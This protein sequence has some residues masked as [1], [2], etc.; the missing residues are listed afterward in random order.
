[1]PYGFWL[2]VMVLLVVGFVLLFLRDSFRPMPHRRDDRDSKKADELIQNPSE[3]ENTQQPSELQVGEA[4]AARRPRRFE[5]D[6]PV[7]RPEQNR[8]GFY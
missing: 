2:L 5:P 7:A 8:P 3:S 4:D 6:S 1:M